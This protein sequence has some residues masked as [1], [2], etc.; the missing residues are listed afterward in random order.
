MFLVQAQAVVKSTKK[1]GREE[2]DFS[3]DEEHVEDLGKAAATGC[4]GASTVAHPS[5][6][7][8]DGRR[9]R[10]ARKIVSM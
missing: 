5:T 7:A 10:K 3:S 8:A 1:C 2:L 9:P 4:A 6:E